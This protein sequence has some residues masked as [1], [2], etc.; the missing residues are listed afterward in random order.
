MRLKEWEHILCILPCLQPLRLTLQE[1]NP[2]CDIP[3]SWCFK[4]ITAKFGI[5]TINREYLDKREKLG[6]LY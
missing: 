1:R 6:R 4:K 2:S 3:S 5:M